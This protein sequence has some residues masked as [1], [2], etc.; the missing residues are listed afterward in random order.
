[1]NPRE[2]IVRPVITEESMKGVE[3]GRYVFAVHPRATKVDIREAVEK[4]FRVRV[5]KVN[6]LWVRGKKRRRGRTEGMTSPWKKA[7]VK[8]APGQKIEFFEGLR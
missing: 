5:E 6:T 7:V 2:V 1:M 3:E 4:L 8:L